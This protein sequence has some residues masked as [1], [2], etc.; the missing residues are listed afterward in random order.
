[1]IMCVPFITGKLFS[2]NENTSLL[3]PFFLRMKP[4]LAIQI[5]FDNSVA[6]RYVKFDP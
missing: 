3:L 4:L 2:N 1:M 5:Q 6:D